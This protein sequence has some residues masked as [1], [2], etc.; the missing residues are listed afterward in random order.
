[1]GKWKKE[2]YKRDNY[3]CV[4]SGKSISGNLIAHHLESY[5]SN[6]ELRTVLS[7]GVTMDKDC[8]IEFHKRYGFGNNTREQ[9]EEFLKEYKEKINLLTSILFSVKIFPRVVKFNSKVLKIG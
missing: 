3:T 6:K 5:G 9:F 7:N 8:H 4:V 1:M 2:V